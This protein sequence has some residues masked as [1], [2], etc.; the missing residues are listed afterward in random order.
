M[1]QDKIENRKS[2]LEIT[3]ELKEVLNK[4]RSALKGSDRR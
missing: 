1:I 2:I 3:P 4:T